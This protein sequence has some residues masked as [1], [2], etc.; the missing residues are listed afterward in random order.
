V[1]SLAL[2]S[3]ASG[4]SSPSARLRAAMMRLSNGRV[5]ARAGWSALARVWRVLLVNWII[6]SNIANGTSGKSAMP[7]AV[8]ECK[9]DRAIA[10]SR[11]NAPSMDRRLNHVPVIWR[12]VHHRPSG[13]SG[14][15]CRRARFHVA[16]G[17][18][19]PSVN[20]LTA[21]LAMMVVVLTST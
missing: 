2:A 19:R 21:Q 5:F 9:S 8:G 13:P 3:G 18:E 15:H 10:V 12:N 20:A 1:R 17:L 16:A 14:R 6:A 4:A 11:D 7:L